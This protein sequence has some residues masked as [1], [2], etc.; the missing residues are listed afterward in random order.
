MAGFQ[1]RRLGL[2]MEPEPG[3]PFEVE[4]VLNPGGV[5]GP[6]GGYYLFPGLSAR[7][8]SRASASRE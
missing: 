4:G 5:R 2:L 1:M 3:N 6:D 8:T 7:E